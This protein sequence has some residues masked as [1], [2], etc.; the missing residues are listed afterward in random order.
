MKKKLLF[1]ILLISL[2][3]AGCQVKEPRSILESISR[4][5][6][7]ISIYR[8][9]IFV[10]QSLKDSDSGYPKISLMSHATIDKAKGFEGKL[11]KKENGKTAHIINVVSNPRATIYKENNSPW[12]HSK[13]PDAQIDRI[14]IM[15]YAQAQDILNIIQT[16]ATWRQL[17][18]GYMVNF[19]GQ[20]AQ[21]R[22]L[23]N[24][25]IQEDYTN[26][27]EHN[28]QVIINKETNYIEKVI[29]LA[30][31]KEYKQNKPMISKIELSYTDQNDFNVAKDFAEISS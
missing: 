4:A 9:N 10:N 3:T 24:Q 26:E 31:G 18:F 17:P 8:Q 27:V 25:I 14:S 30:D 21:L 20:N 29:W 19:D 11:I 6:S 16:D 15:T 1:F 2:F 7:T 12:Q 28:I 5:A 23:I 13:T 22:N